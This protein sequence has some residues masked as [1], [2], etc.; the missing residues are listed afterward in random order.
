MDF[1]N[2]FEDEIRKAGYKPV[3]PLRISG[4]GSWD[5]LYYMNEKRASGRYQL[6]VEGDKAFGIYGSDKDHN[7][8]QVWRSWD[9]L[10]LDNKTIK[11]NK[12]WQDRRRA[13]AEKAEAYRQNK[14]AKMLTSIYKTLPKAD[15]KFKYLVKKEV[16]AHSIIKYR[17]R[18]N[19]L[20][21]P[22]LQMDGKVTSVQYITAKGDKYFF[23]GGRVRGGFLPIRD[24]G[25]DWD[26]IYITEGYATGMSIKKAMNKTVICAFNANNLVPVAKMFKEKYPQARIVI[27][28]DNDQFPSDK[29]PKNKKWVNT[30]IDRATQA[31][32][33]TGAEMYYPEFDEDMIELRPT[34]WNDYARFYGT[35]K[36]K[37][38]LSKKPERAIEKKVE[39]NK[40]EMHSERIIV[41]PEKELW[42]TVKAEKMKWQGNLQYGNPD[43]NFSL[44]N[45][46]LQ[47]LYDPLWKGTFV[48]DEFAGRCIVIKP[49]PWDNHENFHYREVTDSDLTRLRSALM[50][51]LKIK[52]GSKG[53]MNDIIDI[54][55]KDRSIHPVRNYF[56]SLQWD[57][58]ER[59]DNWIID[60]CNPLSGN[61]EYIRRVSACFILAAVKRIYFPGT[62]H[63]QMLVLEGKQDI[64]KSTLLRTLATFN[65]I[66]YFSDRI[67]FK[68]IDN[69]YLCSHLAGNIIVE[70]PELT[71]FSL[72]DRNK[73]KGWISQSEDEMQPKHKMR[74]EKY[75]RQFVLAGSTNDS[76]W[77]NDPTGGVRFWPVHCGKIDI[78]GIE[79]VVLQLWAEAVFRIKNG[80]AHWILDEDPL[81]NVMKAEQAVRYDGHVWLEIISEYTRGKDEINID[82]VLTDAVKIPTERWNQRTKAEVGDCLRELGYESKVVWCSKTKGRRRK[83]LKT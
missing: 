67:T 44:L 66:S 6:H 37:E 22:V 63:K 53:E 51:D 14:I 65:G 28:A 19:C 43:N 61:R 30:G 27:C 76:T 36:I 42:I 20:V 54:V 72:Q 39:T 13:E 1:F 4:S 9:G 17:K 45:A 35:E 80:E 77:M 8:F 62:F 75:A 26:E 16:T 33:E 2:K 41:D 3:K 74:V 29:Y 73:I 38:Q 7:G 70:F 55:S 52:V 24:K 47:L 64:G 83:W 25:E 23:A 81:Y 78:K 57:G 32:G 46:Q 5:R 50:A 10:T 31:A 34:D 48:Y 71:G 18:T 68:D 58:E 40:A 56:D 79:K 59:L 49:L 15:D 11:A 21:L 82:D 69:P 60:Y 12:E